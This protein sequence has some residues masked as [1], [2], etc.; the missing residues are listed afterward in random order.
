M[1]L[2]MVGLCLF[3]HF[4]FFCHFVSVFMVGLRVFG[5]FVSLPLVA[6]CLFFCG[7]CVLGH[8]VFFSFLF[9]WTQGLTTS[10]Y[11]KFCVFDNILK[12]NMSFETPWRDLGF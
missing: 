4:V 1:C 8:F 12:E 5:H 6:L 2:F 7:H 9:W 3:G 10:G 11:G